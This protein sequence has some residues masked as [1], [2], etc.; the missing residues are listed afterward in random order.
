MADQ[1]GTHCQ[2]SEVRKLGIPANRATVEPVVQ[3]TRQ[4]SRE[5]IARSRSQ[6]DEVAP[7]HSEP[8]A[9]KL[10][11]EPLD[12]LSPKRPAARPQHD[13]R[14]G[15]ERVK[16]PVQAAVAQ[17]P[18]GLQGAQRRWATIRGLLRCLRE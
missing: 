2:P 8:H 10:A 15:G 13:D 6:R 12:A 4:Y 3:G 11:H 9:S 14:L 17:T 5:R 7:A 16:E 1:S 18:R